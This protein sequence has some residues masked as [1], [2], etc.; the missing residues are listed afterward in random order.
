MKIESDIIRRLEESNQAKVS[1]V[2]QEQVKTA[3]G[4]KLENAKDAAVDV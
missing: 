3:V 1:L 4:I 2:E